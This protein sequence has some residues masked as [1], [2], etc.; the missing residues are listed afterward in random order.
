M[1]VSR[2]FENGPGEVKLDHLQGYPRVVPGTE[3]QH[4]VKSL[5]E[6]VPLV[7]VNSVE[8]VYLCS[9]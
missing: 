6:A 2:Y 5:G 7:S 8:M 4:T 9:G 3:L 1:D